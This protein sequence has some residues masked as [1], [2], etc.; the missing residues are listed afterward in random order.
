MMENQSN[1]PKPEG[2]RVD[3]LVY[4]LQRIGAHGSAEVSTYDPDLPK[5][6]R[7]RFVDRVLSFNPDD[8]LQSGVIVLI[9]QVKGG[10]KPCE[11]CE[12]VE[13]IAQLEDEVSGMMAQF[14]GV[15]GAQAMFCPL[16][17]YEFA[18]ELE[19]KYGKAKED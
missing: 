18:V 13:Y 1:G 10:P 16:C 14:F 8:V 3:A 17:G 15:V 5:G 2:I 11:F 19:D 7:V 4:E 6:K 9:L 12:K